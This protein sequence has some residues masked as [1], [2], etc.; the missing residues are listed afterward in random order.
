MIDF[1][2]VTAIT[3]PEGNV[4]KITRG[5]EI[6]WEKPAANLDYIV[7]LPRTTYTQNLSYYGGKT[8][9]NDIVLSRAPQAGE[10][11]VVYVNGVAYEDIAEQSGD[12][13]M[14]CYS[15]STVYASSGDGGTTSAYVVVDG[16]HES[17]TI[18]IHYIPKWEVIL[19]EA[20]VS[21][22]Y[23]ESY[24]YTKFLANLSQEISVGETYMFIVN[25]EQMTS[26]AED[27]GSCL[28]MITD[29]RYFSTDGYDLDV[30][31]TSEGGN[32][33]TITLEVRHM[34]Y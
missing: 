12:Q 27:V 2:G 5:T 32:V 30:L 13:I 24:D 22:T 23:N 16:I 7:V 28:E 6:L 1:T 21:G 29:T 11:Y 19:P 18:E 3:I 31:Y 10:K 34:R 15:D 9:V 20:V 25:G 26:V 17:L 8:T 33:P 14:F 4:A